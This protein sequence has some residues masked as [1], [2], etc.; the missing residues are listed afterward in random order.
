MISAFNRN[1]PFDQFTIEQLAGDLLPNATTEQKIA[2]GFNRNHMINFE[3]GAIPEEYQAE[4]MVDRVDT[5]S[6]VWMGATMG[7]A[8]CHDHKYD[9]IKQRDFYSFGAFFNTIPE[10]GLDGRAGNAEPVLA[11]PTPQQKARQDELNYRL[12]VLEDHL[13]ESEIAPKQMR[14]E[15]TALASMPVDPRSGILAH[16]DFEGSFPD[17]SGH[18][19]HGKSLRT[20][21]AF[22]GGP[23]GRAAD[24]GPDSHVRI[25][26]LPAGA[27]SLAM[28]LRPTGSQE[29]SVLHNEG[30]EIA[31]D[32][33]VHIPE[34]KRGAFLCVRFIDRASGK[35]LEWKTRERLIRRDWYHLAINW[36]GSGK[37]GLRLYLN[38]TLHDAELLR[39]DLVGSPNVA[40][41]LEIGDKAN[42]KVYRGSLDDLRIF[43]RALS[44]DEVTVL[45]TH[46]PAQS[47]LETPVAK[48]SKEH[49]VA[50]R[51][52]FLS[53]DA[54]EP[55]RKDYREWV[56]LRRELVELDRNITTVM[57][58]QEMPKPRETFVLGRGDYRNKGDKVT[59]SV[60]AVL[61]PLPRVPQDAAPA[62]RLTLARWLVDPSHP[63]TARV[64]VNRY[65][66]MYFGQGIVKTTED[67]GAQGEAPVHPELLDWLA[68]EFIR[69]GWDVKAMQKLIVMSAA[70]RQSSVVTPKLLEKDPENRLLARGPRFRIPAE[71]IRDTALAAS[72]LLNPA[73][74]GRSVF[75]YSPAGLW[76]EI[77]F[78][79]VYSAQT[80]TPSHG[81]DLYRRSMY[82][83]WKRTAPPSA[84]ITFDA[85]DR[86]KC[87]SRRPVTNTPLQALA[88][89]NEPTFV[90]AART[91][92]QRML[93]EGGKTP[94]QRIAYAFLLTLARKPA[95]AEARVLQNLAVRKAGRLPKQSGSRCKAARRRRIT[96][97]REARSR[98]ARCLDHGCERHSQPR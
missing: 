76:D 62:N 38:G 75:P 19:Q 34:L 31:L 93:Q 94:A 21:I 8:R 71:M 7:C 33:T 52:Y 73:I 3:G 41:P 82:T 43:S 70:Y 35:R 40:K 67:F 11:L 25:A 54:P 59:P 63:L 39:A 46:L 90:E 83:F 55:L 53:R 6:N 32:E 29:S 16:Y 80:Y 74:G 50:L 47:I 23:V 20:E 81:A 45:A 27:F 49:K 78:G 69:T 98:R 44:S 24:F 89:L 12:A 96:I 57:V 85:P 72:G 65:W 88:L 95:A 14:W 91:L 36:A 18:Y 42:G 58:M 15:K 92:A 66:Q 64:A 2:T 48:R 60:P 28:W 86:E 26:A 84:M 87:A 13:P 68:T 5:T 79:D 10:K 61:P 9:P 30:F 1:L 97:R 4:Y 22:T 77:S 17:L 56:A 37:Q 51:D